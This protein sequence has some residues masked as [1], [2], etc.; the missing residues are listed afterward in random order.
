MMTALAQEPD[1]TADTGVQEAMRTLTAQW[2]NAVV[3]GCGLDPGAFQLV[4]GSMSIG[5]DPRDLWSRLDAIPPLSVSRHFDPSRFRRFSSDYAAVIGSLLVPGANELALALG[6]F[7]QHWLD[8]PDK[9]LGTFKRFAMHNNPDDARRW[10]RIYAQLNLNPVAR[11]RD[12][13]DNVAMASRN[14]DVYAYNATLDDLNARLQSVPG[15]SVKMNSRTA[16]SSLSH[17]WARGMGSGMFDGF[18]GEAGGE[19]RDFAETIADASITVKC[20][21]DR[22]LTFS[23]DPLSQAGETWPLS[24]YTPWYIPAAM[25]DAHDDTSNLVWGYRAPVWADAFGP[26]GSLG[27]VCTGLVVVD[28]INIEVTTDASFSSRQ[29]PSVQAAARAGFFPFFEAGVPGRWENNVTFGDHGQATFRSSSRLGNPHVLGAIA[30][31]IRQAVDGRHHGRR[32][33]EN[34]MLFGPV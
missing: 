3:G 9:S 12:K 10:I 26:T 22:L 25:A 29:Y 24:D 4:Q 34:Y 27:R 11:A 20:S 30:T 17:T 21:F 33:P 5:T 32:H 18:F 19:S 6:P 28:G 14:H 31:P 2:Y 1:I 13:L 15:K 16:A 7:Y 23:A 8:T